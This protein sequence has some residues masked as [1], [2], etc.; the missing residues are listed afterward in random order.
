MPMGEARMAPKRKAAEEAT[1]EARPS[2]AACS[3]EQ[4]LLM[5][6]SATLGWRARAAKAAKHGD[7]D[8]AMMRAEG[9][10]AE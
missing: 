6:A 9:G 7:D 3:R 4:R 8:E 5:E 10:L 1:T 2:E